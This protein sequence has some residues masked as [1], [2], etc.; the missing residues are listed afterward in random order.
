MDWPRLL[1][2][3]DAPHGL[4]DICVTTGRYGVAT[5]VSNESASADRLKVF[6]F[7]APCPPG[8]SPVCAAAEP[9]LKPA[10][11]PSNP[12]TAITWPAR[13]RGAASGP[14]RVMRA[15]L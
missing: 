10:V 9:A 7:P 4:A 8:W 5:T 12:T 14:V 6:W 11:A 13:A 1:R 2:L 3:A 15:P